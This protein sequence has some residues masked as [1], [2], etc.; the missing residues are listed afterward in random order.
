[1]RTKKLLALILAVVMVMSLTAC[2]SKYIT[3]TDSNTKCYNFATCSGYYKDGNYI[4]VDEFL[5]ELPAVDALDVQE[6]YDTIEYNEKMLYGW[7][8]LNNAKSAIKKYYKTAKTMDVKLPSDY[9]EDYTRT[10]CSLPIGMDC[11]PTRV[12][13]ARY[14]RDLE[15][16]TLMF[17]DE[18]GKNKVY[19]D[20]TYTVSGNTVTFIPLAELETLLDENYRTIGYEY[21]PGTQELTYEFSFDGPNITLSNADG[22]ITLTTY[23]YTNGATP[24]ISGYLAPDSPMIGN[25]DSFDCYISTDVFDQYSSAWIDQEGESYAPRSAV[26][27]YDNGLVDFYWVHTDADDNETVY[28]EQFVYF[29]TSPMVLTD[30]EN[31]YYYTESY[32]T[33]EMLLMGDGM[34]TEDLIEFDS[35]AENEQQQIIEKKANLLSDLSAAFAEAGLAVQINHSTGEIALDSAV[36]FGVDQ[37]AISAEGKVFLQQFLSVYT[38]VVFGDEYTDFVS[39][40]IVEGHTD[41]SGAYDYNLKLSQA[42]ADNVLAFCLS[43]EAG[44]DA[45]YVDSLAATLEAVGYSCDKPIYDENGQIDMDASRRVSFRFVINIGE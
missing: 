9:I 38:S 45:A 30:G 22:S 1:M 21:T 17:L 34:S 11:G 7:Y 41:T 16:A 42:R 28:H 29:G 43:D 36:L 23:N 27:F 39:K 6:I 25:M 12:Y 44:V 10:L 20:C 13:M 18:D 3:K 4:K 37:S 32:T 35:M 40:I 31:I 33:R 2:S 14:V 5:K 19:V 24:R 15:W 8:E 26:R